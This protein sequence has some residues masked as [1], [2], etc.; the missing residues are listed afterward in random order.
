MELQVI[1]RRT[2]GRKN[3]KNGGTGPGVRVRGK[4]V[5]VRTN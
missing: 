5:G 4:M 1:E 2:G 3:G